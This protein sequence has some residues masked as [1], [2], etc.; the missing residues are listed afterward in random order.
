MATA[1]HTGGRSIPA[2]LDILISGSE[3]AATRALRALFIVC[4]RRC[5]RSSSAG[6]SKSGFRDGIEIRLLTDYGVALHVVGADL[7]PARSQ[8]VR[9]RVWVPL[10]R[11]L[12]P[13]CRRSDLIALQQNSDRAKDQ[14][15]LDLLHDSS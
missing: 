13:V 9:N 6:F 2:D 11:G 12:V 5:T 7:V 10:D 3:E 1:Y 15:G 14:L 8:V 4:R